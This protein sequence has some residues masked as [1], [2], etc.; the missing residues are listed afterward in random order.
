MNAGRNI[1]CFIYTSHSD[2]RLWMETVRSARL[3]DSSPKLLQACTAA[4]TEVISRRGCGTTGWLSLEHHR[5]VTRG[6]SHFHANQCHGDAAAALWCKWVAVTHGAR[7]RGGEGDLGDFVKVEALKSCLPFIQRPSIMY[8]VYVQSLCRE[9]PSAG[10]TYWTL[11]SWLILLQVLFLDLVSAQL[12][13]A[14]TGSDK[15]FPINLDLKIPR[16]GVW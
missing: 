15:Y 5:A 8:G 3:K 14:G 16:A 2:M 4:L 1:S 10:L 6:T 7:R 13:T 12:P 11:W 9:Y